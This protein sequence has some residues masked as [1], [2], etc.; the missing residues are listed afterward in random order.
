M[1]RT[2]GISTRVPAFPSIALGAADV[3]PIEMISAYSTFANLGWR[4]P[5][6]PLLLV[7]TLD[8]R[9]LYEADPQ[10]DRQQVLS[11][12]EAWIMVDM[13]KDA[14]RRGTGTAVWNS[15]FRTP[16]GG[17]TGTTNDFTDVWYVGFTSD[18]VAGAWMGF[19]QPKEIMPNAQG[20]RLA[21]P[22][23]IAF[24]REVYERKP[25]PPDWPRPLGILSVEIDP[26]TGLRAGPGCWSDSVR[27]EYFIPGTEPQ[28]ECPRRFP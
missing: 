6:N 7:E 9:K 21:A 23:W 28:T 15:G 8:G 20:G 1:A 12:E 3:Y 16:S 13:L 4:V 19:D 18:L 2:F 17:K 22:A 14:V 26:A 11:R 5:P 27:V 24:M 10:A 25:T